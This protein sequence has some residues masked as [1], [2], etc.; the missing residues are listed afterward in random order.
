V[1]AVSETL[2]IEALAQE[3]GLSNT[4]P[5]QNLS[6]CGDFPSC[7]FHPTRLRFAS[8][9]IFTCRLAAII[10]GDGSASG[11]FCLLFGLSGA[12]WAEKRAK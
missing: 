4:R 9:G 3:T 12:G 7:Q 5:F 8:S 2:K 11:H 10:S 1:G 6:H